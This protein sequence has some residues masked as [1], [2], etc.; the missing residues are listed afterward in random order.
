MKTSLENKLI[1]NYWVNKLKLCPVVNDNPLTLYE[2]K[3]RII[4]KEELSYFNKLTANNEM[5]EFTVLL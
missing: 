4:K 3:E 2:T 1:V 5:V